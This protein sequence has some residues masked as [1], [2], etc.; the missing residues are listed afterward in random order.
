MDSRAWPAASYVYRVL[1]LYLL[2]ALAAAIITSIVLIIIF[3]S[4]AVQTFLAGVI[5]GIMAGVFIQYL[6]AK[7]FFTRLAR[8]IDAVLHATLIFH[9]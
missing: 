1:I 8:M 6:L 7:G 4:L 2:A 3:G 9:S 5:T